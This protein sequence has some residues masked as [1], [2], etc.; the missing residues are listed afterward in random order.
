MK[1]VIVEIDESEFGK[2]K[3]NRGHRVEGVWI[4]GGIER[5]DNIGV[6]LERVENRNADTLVEIIHR[7]VRPG[8]IIYTDLWRG[9]TG[10]ADSGEY[11]HGTVNHSQFFRDPTTGVHTNTIEGYWN[12]LKMQIKPRS[13][14]KEVIEDH[15]FE[16]IWRAKFKDSMWTSFLAALKDVL[17]Q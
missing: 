16:N 11:S 17:Y 8:S 6:F 7:R 13:R 4:V 10:I 1:G 3:Y 5:S 15:L 12:G 14:V 2:R 9:Y